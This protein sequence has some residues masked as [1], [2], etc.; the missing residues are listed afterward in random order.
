MSQ[1]VLYYAVLLVQLLDFGIEKLF[2]GKISSMGSMSFDILATHINTHYTY[3]HICTYTHTHTYNR[4]FHPRWLIKQ[5]KSTKKNFLFSVDKD[6]WD[7][8]G[9]YT[10]S[11]ILHVISKVSV[12]LV[13]SDNPVGPCFY[14]YRASWP[15]FKLT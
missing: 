14:P 9:Y 5:S 7:L 12:M 1:Y 13:L 2:L 15:L 3:T 6:I 4:F 11:C 10:T 8:V